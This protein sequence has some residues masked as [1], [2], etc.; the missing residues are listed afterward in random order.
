MR[1]RISTALLLIGMVVCVARAD[2]VQFSTSSD[3]IDPSRQTYLWAWN[4]MQLTFVGQ[5]NTT[6]NTPSIASLGEFIIT[7]YAGTDTFSSVPFDL[8][9]TQWVPAVAANTAAFTSI[10]DGR[11]SLGAS[12][13]TVT[14]LEPFV[15]IGDVVYTLTQQTYT[16]D[17]NGLSGPGETPIQAQIAVNPEPGTWVLM[18]TGLLILA[19]VVFKRSRMNLNPGTTTAV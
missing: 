1:K 8:T 18:G 5:T 15:T 19:F 6:V 3:P 2:T 17:A 9:I 13:A 7:G 10:I 11:I 16:L 14:F 4:N 12:S